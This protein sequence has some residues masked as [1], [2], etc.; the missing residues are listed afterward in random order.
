MMKPRHRPKWKDCGGPGTRRGDQ[1]SREIRTLKRMG[2][3]DELVILMAL[4]ETSR[5]IQRAAR[6][7]RTTP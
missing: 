2:F 6:L 4:K 1:F 3:N 5:N 7:M